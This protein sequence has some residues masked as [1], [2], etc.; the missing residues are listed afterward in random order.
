[1]TAHQKMNKSVST[2]LFLRN[3]QGQDLDQ[4]STELKARL[5]KLDEMIEE[6]QQRLTSMTAEEKTELEKRSKEIA[7]MAALLLSER[8]SH[9]T[10]QLIHVDGGYVHLDRSLE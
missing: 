3:S 1:M 2:P 4:L 7:D 8:S 10:G 9:T 5:K 6:R